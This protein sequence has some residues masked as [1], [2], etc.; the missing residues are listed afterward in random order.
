M[1]A[2]LKAYDESL[3]LG[4]GA[5]LRN[6]TA[7]V[8]QQVGMGAARPQLGSDGDWKAVFFSALKTLLRETLYTRDPKQREEHLKHVHRWFKEKQEQ[9]DR[10]DETRKSGKADAGM[11]KSSLR[12]FGASRASRNVGSTTNAIG[13]EAKGGDD[14]GAVVGNEAARDAGAS[15][16]G[17][18]L[19]R[20]SD[21]DA[22]SVSTL[23]VGGEFSRFRTRDL[24]SSYRKRLESHGLPAVPAANAKQ[25]SLPSAD[26]ERITPAAKA[27]YGDPSTWTVPGAVSGDDQPDFHARHVWTDAS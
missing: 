2:A 25:Y 20:S 15:D 4:T 6:S 1:N 18:Q 9:F 17:Q 14:W 11:P 22:R 26:L 27:V 3:G 16:L 10:V 13:T 23:S 7:V 5:P 24:T 12:G 21:T 19:S 8:E